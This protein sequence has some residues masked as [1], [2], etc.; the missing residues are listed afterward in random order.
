MDFLKKNKMVTGGVILAVLLL[1]GMLFFSGNT[2]TPTLSSSADPSEPSVSRDLL[3]T[4]SNL[5]TLRLDGSIF[6]NPAFVSLTDYGV[7]IPP[8]PVGRRNPFLSLTAPPPAPPVPAA[9]TPA[10]TKTKT[11]TKTPTTTH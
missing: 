11:P 4:L 10:S 9:S 5:H 1:L 8:Q 7:I 6:S 3:V 2:N